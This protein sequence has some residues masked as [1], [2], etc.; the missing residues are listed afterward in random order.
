MALPVAAQASPLELFVERTAMATADLRCGFFDSA[1]R[2][3]L[4]AGRAQSRNAALRAGASAQALAEAEARGRRAGSAADCSAP[5][6]LAAADHVRQ[7]F[8]GFTRLRQAVYPGEAADWRADRSPSADVHLWRLVQ[9]GQ[10]DQGRMV[11]GLAGRNGPP[12][13]L[14]LASF[15]DGAVPYAARLVF[16][17]EAR[18][19][20][21]YLGVGGELSRRLPPRDAQVSFP[22]EARSRAGLDLRPKEMGAGWAFR[23]PAAA[24]ARLARLDPREAVAVEFLFSSGA[25]VRRAYVEVGDFAPGQAFIQ[26]ATR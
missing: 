4:E 22:A 18:A 24:T 1:L 10:F 20:A 3:A 16:R 25:A 23:F 17:D 12:V 21:P 15:D 13:L 8:Q 14:A 7:A 11:F 26:L 6:V 19:A 2:P 5:D 9:T